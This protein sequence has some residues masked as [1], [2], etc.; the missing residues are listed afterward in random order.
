MTGRWTG[1][2]AYLQIAADYRTKIL[3]GSLP[4]GAKLPSESQLTTEYDVSRQVVK[5]ALNLLRS[6]GLITSHQGKGNFVRQRPPARRVGSNRYQHEIDQITR[7]GSSIPEP[8]TSF[9]KDHDIGWSDYHLDKDFHRVQADNRLADL[10]HVEPGEPILDRSFVFYAKG[11][12]Q[13]MSR[14]R[15]LLKHVDG[16]PIVDPANE[17]WP[18]GNIAQLATLGILV[19][20][21]EESVTSRMPLPNE[22]ETLHI[23]TGVPVIV[24]TRR[25]LTGS[26]RNEVVEVADII[27]PADRTVLDYTIDLNV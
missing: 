19:N 10:F 24:I 7:N 20:R 1:I 21:I 3:D 26:D 14:S 9:T 8:A 2:P 15:L 11:E 12:P 18:G 5:M 25:M 6:E 27:I 16:T 13:Q 17:P 22:T 23:P 4:A